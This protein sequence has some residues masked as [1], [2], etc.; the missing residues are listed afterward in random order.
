MSRS[1]LREEVGTSMSES[2]KSLVFIDLGSFLNNKGGSLVLLVPETGTRGLL[3][4]TKFVHS[5][6]LYTSNKSSLE[7][8]SARFSGNNVLNSIYSTINKVKNGTV[9][10]EEENKG[11]EKEISRLLAKAGR[12]IQ[13]K[14]TDEEKQLFVKASADLRSP[15]LMLI[16]TIN[17]KLGSTIEAPEPEEEPAKEKAPDKP[18]EEP[19]EKPAPKAEPKASPKVEPK[20]TPKAE[21]KPEEEPK[22][23]DSEDKPEDKEVTKSEAI[24]RIK[25]MIR[26]MILTELKKKK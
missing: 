23:D 26:E 17:Q 10:S 20:A 14:L 3:K 6:E 21:P 5:N 15:A 24:R 18:A 9:S 16:N 19:T 8:I 12:F 2:V 4:W 7:A 22:D 11:R 13:N 1:K 25:K